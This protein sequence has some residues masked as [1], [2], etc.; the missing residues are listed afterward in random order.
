MALWD[1][2]SAG[3]SFE[4]IF[5]KG[6]DKLETMLQHLV[7]KNAPDF[8]Y[9]FNLG[10]GTKHTARHPLLARLRQLVDGETRKRIEMS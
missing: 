5:A 6:F 4:A 8:D 9:A 3:E 2:Y 7:G 10:Y 1:E